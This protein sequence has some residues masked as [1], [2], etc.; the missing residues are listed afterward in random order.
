MPALL[1]PIGLLKKYVSDQTNLE[2]PVGVS[3]RSALEQV[4]IP[5]QLVALVL[6]NGQSQTKDYLIQD[7]DDIQIL[8]I[9]GGG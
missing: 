2:I 9:V 5:G 6:V 4:G 8:A 7:G 3:V 1:R